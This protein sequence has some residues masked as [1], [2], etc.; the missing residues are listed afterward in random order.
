MR[1]FIRQTLSSLLPRP[2]AMRILC[3]GLR[4][5]GCGVRA[6][7][8]RSRG[9][10]DDMQGVLHDSDNSDHDSDNSDHV[11]R[12]HGAASASA[13]L[14]PPAAVSVAPE[15]ARVTL[16]PRGGVGGGGG[17]DG[18]EGGGEGPGGVG[19][20]EAGLEMGSDMVVVGVQL[21]FGGHFGYDQQWNDPAILE[22][23]DLRDAAVCLGSLIQ[24]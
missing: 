11:C 17:G 23:R 3:G 6:G 19:G 7:A 18:E 8:A 15:A 14:A 10:L 5:A 12:R 20:E 24:V 16:V 2:L 1:A 4:C 22:P 13:G 9:V 21:R